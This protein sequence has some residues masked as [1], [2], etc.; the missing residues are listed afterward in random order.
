[1]TVMQFPVSDNLG[2]SITLQE[3]VQSTNEESKNNCKKVLKIPESYKTV[4][5]L[6]VR[7]TP[8]YAQK[9]S[10]DISEYCGDEQFLA[11]EKLKEQSWLENI[12]DIDKIKS[13]LKYHSDNASNVSVKVLN[14]VLSII[15]KP[16]HTLSTQYH[17]MEIIKKTINHLNPGQTPVDVCVQP[18]YTLTKEIH[19][20]YPD[21]FGNSS[22]FCRFGGLHFEQCI[23]TI[24]GE[25]IK[26]SGLENVLLNMDM[27]IIGTG[28]VI[29]ANHIKQSRYCFQTSL[30]ALFIKLKTAKEKSG[31]GL[32][33][34]EKL[35]LRKN[36]NDISYYWYLIFTLQLDILLYIR[37]LRESNY[38]LLV[39]AMENLMKWVFSF[40]RVH[41][42]RWRT[43]HVLI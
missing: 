12:S 10:V 19:W 29:N 41:Y 39:Y 4:K 21:R 9:I 27:S 40:D 18:V 11:S 8:L 32:S 30:C 24:H 43:V 33:V 42:A 6:S 37:S 28:S 23:L 1:M 34:F 31:S 16:V 22:Y 15:P 26:G 3:C 36:Q 35:E 20:R 38:K 7:K 13:W 14:A 25:L 5:F 17:C 2:N